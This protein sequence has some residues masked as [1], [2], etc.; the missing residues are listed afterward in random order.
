MNNRK[1]QDLDQT[2][3]DTFDAYRPAEIARRPV[4]KTI[5]G[6]VALILA[7]VAVLAAIWLPWHWQ[8]GATALLTLIVG[9]ALLGNG[10]R[11]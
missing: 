4:W 2:I 11:K 1:T 3:K 9:S 8:F 10:A 5:S 6:T 7:L